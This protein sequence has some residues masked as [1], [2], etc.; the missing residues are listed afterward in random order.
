[1][2]RATTALL[3]T[4]AFAPLACKPKH[5]DVRTIEEEE[6]PALATIV[7]MAD[8]RTAGQL[9]SGFYDV[10]QNA[11]RWT[12]GHFSVALPPPRN[13]ALKGATLELKFT[14]PDVSI[15]KL[16]TISLSASINGAPLGAETYAQAGQFTYS[17][18]I[19]A[20]ALHGDSVKVDFALDKSMPPSAE[21]QRELGIVA[22]S[23]ALS[24]RP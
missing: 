6:G 11:W 16:K 2:R 8:P 14:V 3:L 13:A 18:D 15:A 9:V 17:R 23:V 1:M 20:S 12:A 5:A 7:H 19:P 4:M 10:E 21:D 24:A 22:T